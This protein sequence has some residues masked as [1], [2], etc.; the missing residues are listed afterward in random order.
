MSG[1]F[2]D[3]IIDPKNMTV[4]FEIHGMPGTRCK[5]VTDILRKGKKVVHEQV[6]AEYYGHVDKDYVTL[7]S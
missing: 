7:D 3:V 6:T 1:E 2:V 5:N 4:E